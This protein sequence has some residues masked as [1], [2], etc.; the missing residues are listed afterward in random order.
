MCI[1]TI[2]VNYN[3]FLEKNNLNYI[4]LKIITIHIYR[5]YLPIC[6]VFMIVILVI[7]FNLLYF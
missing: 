4:S 7:L 3:I 5:Y 1:I 2:S 6:S